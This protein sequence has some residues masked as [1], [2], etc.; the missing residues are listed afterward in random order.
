MTRTDDPLRLFER[1]PALDVDDAE[2]TR[3]QRELRVLRRAQAVN[4]KLP[5]E[6]TPTPVGRPALWGAAAAAVLL[7]ALLVPAIDLAPDAVPER[8]AAAVDP[9]VVERLE[10]LPLVE[11]LV[12]ARA[13]YE[14]EAGDLDLVMIVGDGLDL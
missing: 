2:I 6:R 11:E 13:V 14:I 10:R 1:L 9:A 7:V 3:M 8:T 4:E 12:P 5:E